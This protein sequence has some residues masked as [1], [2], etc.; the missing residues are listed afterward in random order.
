MREFSTIVISGKERRKDC[1]TVVN[2]GKESGRVQ[3]Y[4]KYC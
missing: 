1:S 4:C 3:C 2:T